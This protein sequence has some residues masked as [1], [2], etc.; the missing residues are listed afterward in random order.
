MSNCLKY[1]FFKLMS[2]DLN[3][4]QNFK[5]SIFL[6]KK[7]SLI[8]HLLLQHSW[9]WGFDNK[10]SAVCKINCLKINILKASSSFAQNMDFSW[11]SK[12]RCI[13]NEWPNVKKKIN[14]GIY[15]KRQRRSRD[16][17]C[18]F[19]SLLTKVIVFFLTDIFYKN[20]VKEK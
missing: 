16:I 15:M 13:Y 11:G 9:D 1:I 14:I 10:H 12:E 20:L 7:S 8:V 18:W 4:Y 3:V 17:I 2:V 19:L 6:I 5:C